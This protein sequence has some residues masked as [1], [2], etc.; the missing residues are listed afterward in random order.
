MH[1][2]YRIPIFSQYALNLTIHSILD[3]NICKNEKQTIVK[4]A[5]LEIYAFHIITVNCEITGANY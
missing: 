2:I 1:F 3:K 4:L 5:N